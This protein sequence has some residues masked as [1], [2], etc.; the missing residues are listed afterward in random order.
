MR[1]YDKQ[2][3]FFKKKVRGLCRGHNRTAEGLSHHETMVG[4]EGKE[5]FTL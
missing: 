1:D 5:T 2:E 3:V 4:R